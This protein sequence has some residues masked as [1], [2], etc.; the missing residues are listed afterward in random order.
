MSQDVTITDNT[1]RHRFEAHLGDVVAGYA[2]YARSDSVVVYPH[3]AVGDA[4]AG[5][6]I[7]GLLARAALD[8]ARARGLT[9]VPRCPFIAA[10]IDKHP[11]YA[12]LVH[13]DTGAV[14][15]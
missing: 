11:D 2:Q 7:G 10:W 9:V 5:Q 14:T 8:D 4:Y 3:T 15:D 6:G 12:D 1:A 13:Q